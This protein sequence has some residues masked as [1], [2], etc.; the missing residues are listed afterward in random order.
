MAPATAKLISHWP[1]DDTQL[2]LPINEI[3]SLLSQV[4]LEV[5]FLICIFMIH[6][7]LMIFKYCDIVD[8]TPAQLKRLKLRIIHEILVGMLEKSEINAF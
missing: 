4:N 8:Y 6:S 5:I 2:P 3:H 7:I 1:E